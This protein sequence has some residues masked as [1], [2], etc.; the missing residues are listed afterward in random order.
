MT[1]FLVIG[2]GIV[3]LSTALQLKREFPTAAV[4]LIEKEEQCG[5]HASGRNSGVLHAGFYYS[6]DS[7]KARFS[8]D[9]NR[10]LTAYCDRKD[11]PIRKCGK[12]VVVRDDSQL[13]VAADLLQ[14]ATAN[15]VPLERISES[16]AK[17]IEPSVRTAGCALFSPTTSSVS[18]GQVMQSL[19]A[20]A[21]AG[22]IDIRRSTRYLS[23]AG[24]RVAT[25][26]GSI[27]AG[28]LVNAAG[29]YADTI[30]HNYGFGAD[31]R[32][33]P[34]KGRYLTKKPG[35]DQ[36]RT[37][38][39]PLPD[40]RYPFLGVHYT[41][42]VDGT[43]KIGPTALPALW[44]EQYAGLSRFRLDEL[45]E[46]GWREAE[47]LVTTGWASVTSPGRRSGRSPGRDSCARL[48]VGRGIHLGGRVAVGTP[49]IRAQLFHTRSRRLEMDFVVEGD[50]RSFHVLN[51]VSPAFTCAFP[52][53][54]HI[55]GEIRSRLYGQ[56]A[57]S[58]ATGRTGVRGEPMVT[59]M[60]AG[61]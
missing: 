32:I 45:T 42:A 23:H 51:A 40:L 11:L 37:H 13:S 29:L 41:V 56:P 54:R 26:G 43:L 34:F 53:A 35:A 33:L 50:D 10:E 1:D 27:E 46:I 38:V 18:P 17:E 8:R 48:R 3:G 36:L 31:Y 15:G 60:E 44:R 5:Q 22:G 59:G 9:G 30:A 2:G 49:G 39:Y 61:T 55:V 16:E 12:L 7:L 6:A 20:D 47:L 57:S 24:T 52:F 28:Y 58:P 4:T 14:R 19:E 25:S 21:E